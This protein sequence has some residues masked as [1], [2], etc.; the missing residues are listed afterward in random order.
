MTGCPAGQRWSCPAAGWGRS[1]S[2][3]PAK[4]PIIPL[5]YKSQRLRHTIKFSLQRHEQAMPI[6]WQPQT[7]Q[8]CGLV[9]KTE[10]QTGFNIPGGPW[11]FSHASESWDGV[12][13]CP[14]LS[15]DQ[16]PNRS[17]QI[18]NPWDCLIIIITRFSCQE[19]RCVL[20]TSCS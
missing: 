13:V 5:L 10:K 17:R 16:Q 6:C 14:E 15:A 7:M 18:R 4:I 19:A 12:L 8:D 2:L 3:P 20:Q 11:N 9:L 1:E